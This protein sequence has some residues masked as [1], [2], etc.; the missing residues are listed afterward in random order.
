MWRCVLRNGKID[1]YSNDNLKGAYTLLEE[2]F[3]KYCSSPNTTTENCSLHTQCHSFARAFAMGAYFPS[4]GN[5]GSKGWNDLLSKHI[6]GLK[7]YPNYAVPLGL[8]LTLCIKHVFASLP[9]VDLIVPVPKHATE[10][11]VSHDAQKRPYNQAIELAKVISSKTRIPIAEAL[12]KIRAQKMKGLSEDDRCAVV[13][14]I[15]Q[16]NG[17]AKISEKKILILDDVLTSG[18]TVSECSSVLLQNGVQNVNVL[19]A[20]RDTFDDGA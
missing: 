9:K 11:K 14:G 17:N 2:P 10:Y 5:P 19:V 4:R 16:I 12:I 1:V 20:G 3:C 6:R 13:K 15:Y 18:A 8:G 7:M